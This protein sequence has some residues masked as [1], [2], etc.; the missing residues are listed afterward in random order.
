MG[1]KIEKIWQI[2]RQCSISDGAAK[3]QE[4]SEEYFLAFK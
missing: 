3:D 4:S 2:L 1:Q